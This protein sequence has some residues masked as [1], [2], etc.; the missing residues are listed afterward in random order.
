MKWLM[1]IP[2]MLLCLSLS[3][4]GSRTDVVVTDHDGSPVAG[5]KVQ[6]LAFTINDRA[7]ITGKKGRVAVPWTTEKVKWLNVSARGFK[8]SAVIFTGEKEQTVVLERRSEP[9]HDEPPSMEL[10]PDGHEEGLDV[11]RL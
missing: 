8:R 4:C 2:L 7:K 11:P 6:P 3:G 10:P 5:A 1:P 9:R